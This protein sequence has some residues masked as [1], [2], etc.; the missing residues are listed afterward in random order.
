MDFELEAKWR[1]TLK[2]LE[3]RFGGGMDLQAVMFLIGLQELKT[4]PR[5]LTKDQKLDVMH[6][7]VCTLL[8]PFGYFEYAGDD[9]DGWP[10]F[11]VIKP[12]PA[13]SPNDQDRLMKEA[14][15]EYF[16][17]SLTGESSLG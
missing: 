6:V 7:A 16:G 11:D 8:A 13:L 15:F 5:K 12:M 3:E 9:E 14:I 10:H 2:K 4:K 17:E 1:N